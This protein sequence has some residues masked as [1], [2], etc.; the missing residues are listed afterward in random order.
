MFKTCIFVEFFI[1]LEFRSSI[2]T[3]NSPKMFK[4]N[5]LRPG[6]AKALWMC[7]F[8]NADQLNT[9]VNGTMKTTPYELV[10]GQPSRQ[11]IFLGVSGIG[12]MEEDVQDLLENCTSLDRPQ[13]H[14]NS[15]ECE[16]TS[17][18]KEPQLPS[19]LDNPQP[20]SDSQEPQPP[21]DS[22]EPELHFNRDNPQ[23]PSDSQEPWPFSNS[24]EPLPLVINNEPF[25]TT[26]EKHKK[27]RKEA[28]VHYRL[29]AERM[30]LKYSKWKRIRSSCICVYACGVECGTTAT[31]TS[32]FIIMN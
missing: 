14:F 5:W 28:D 16:P 13:Q 10:F 7:V 8:F 12:I 26:S 29:N 24:Q 9:T 17:D 22:Q 32:T 4:L 30:Q 1:F 15:Q 19:N 23:P 3:Y 11:S 2:F 20:P 27:I 6:P 25:L 21:F 18:S 31:Q